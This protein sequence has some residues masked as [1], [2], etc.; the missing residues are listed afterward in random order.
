M[1]GAQDHAELP[2]D[3]VVLLMRKKCEIQVP[4]IVE[5]RSTAGKAAGKMP[6]VRFQ[7]LYLQFFPGVLVLPDHDRFL[8]LPEIE[9]ALVFRHMIQQIFL[10]RLIAVGQESIRLIK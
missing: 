5:Y 6:A 1:T 4:Q 3:V 2:V 8:V 10:H 9:D 7:L